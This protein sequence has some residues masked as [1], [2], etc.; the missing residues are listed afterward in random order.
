[1]MLG[2]GYAAEKVLD[3]NR[4][5]WEYFQK[6]NYSNGRSLTLHGLSGLLLTESLDGWNG[7][8]RMATGDNQKEFDFGTR[9]TRVNIP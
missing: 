3:T 9:R 5:K 4:K 2:G 7:I 8:V 1:M 6:S